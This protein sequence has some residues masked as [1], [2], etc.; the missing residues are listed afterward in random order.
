MK[1]ITV[2]EMAR[3]LQENPAA[4]FIDVREPEEYAEVRAAGTTNIP[5]SGIIGRLQ[6]LDLSQEVYLIC[7]AGGRSAQVGEYLQ[8]A[9]GAEQVTNVTGGTAE[10]V[11]QGLPSEK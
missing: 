6:E 11:A 2:A 4:Q 10:W 3:I 1:N 5:M 7:Q 9:V 8:E